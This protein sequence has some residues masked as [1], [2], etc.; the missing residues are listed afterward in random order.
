[1]ARVFTQRKRKKN[2]PMLLRKI[3]QTISTRASLLVRRSKILLDKERDKSK[4]HFTHSGFTRQVEGHINLVTNKFSPKGT[5]RHIS[6][7]AYNSR[8][9]RFKPHTI[10]QQ[11][12]G[13]LAPYICISL[14]SQYSRRHQR[15]K[16]KEKEPQ[17]K[18]SKQRN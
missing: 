11:Q 5:K 10:K 4:I 12:W 16:L 2:S 14:T 7:K 3:L 15:L 13:G 8:K 1:M 9:L 6:V 17:Q 18:Y